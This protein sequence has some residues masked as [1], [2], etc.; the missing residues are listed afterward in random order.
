[1]AG[2]SSKDEAQARSNYFDLKRDETMALSEYL[3]SPVAVKDLKSNPAPRGK[4]RGGVDLKEDKKK[5]EKKGILADAMDKFGNRLKF[6]RSDEGKA[7]RKARKLHNE[8]M[9]PKDKR[10]RAKLVRDAAKADAEKGAKMLKKGGTTAKKHIME[11]PTNVPR[12]QRGANLMNPS[13][14]DLDK[15]GTLSSYEKARGRA[16]EKSINERNKPRGT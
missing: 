8:R 3:E 9:G 7:E 16:I 6:R 12:L 5:D 13:K 11:L 10:T 15:D 1:M 4:D 14:A 2:L